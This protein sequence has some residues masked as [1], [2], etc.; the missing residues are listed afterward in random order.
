MFNRVIRR[1]PRWPPF[2][3]RRFVSFTFPQIRALL[4][5]PN[6]FIAGV[7]A[8][9]LL[10]GQLTEKGNKTFG[11]AKNIAWRCIA[12]TYFHFRFLAIDFHRRP[13]IVRFRKA[14]PFSDA[15][16]TDEKLDEIR[17]ARGI[18]M[19]T[20]PRPRPPAIDFHPVPNSVLGLLFYTAARSD[21][22]RNFF[23]D[24]SPLSRSRNFPNHCLRKSFLSY[25]T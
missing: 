18:R 13:S 14:P 4:C 8:L 9:S 11:E 23:H 2:Y 20:I 6:S 25:F 16:P 1:I 12:A 3:H 7:S 24:V 5:F 19:S 15:G 17:K 21:A 22:R 10:S